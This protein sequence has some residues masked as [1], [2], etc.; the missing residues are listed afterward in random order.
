MRIHSILTITAAL[1]LSL[2]LSAGQRHRGD[3]GRRFDTRQGPVISVQVGTPFGFGLF[4]RGFDRD[5]HFDRYGDRYYLDSRRFKQR[6]KFLKKL[7]KQRLREERRFHNRRHHGRGS[8][9]RH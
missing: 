8:E 5:R 3:D 2:P 7:R 1:A 9:W 6:Q 4:N